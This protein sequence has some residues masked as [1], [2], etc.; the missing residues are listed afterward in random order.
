MTILL[1]FAE[2]HMEDFIWANVVNN[3]VGII[4]KKKHF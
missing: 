1:M 4:E 2:S 3:F